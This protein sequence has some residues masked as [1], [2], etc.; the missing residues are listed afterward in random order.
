MFSRKD[1]FNEIQHILGM[2]RVVEIS[3]IILFSLGNYETI[4][5]IF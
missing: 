4:K 1:L 2:T 5:I 3:I